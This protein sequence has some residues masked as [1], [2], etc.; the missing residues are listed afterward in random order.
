MPVRR[1]LRIPGVRFGLIPAA[2]FDARHA[3]AA[4][5]PQIKQ[6][7]ADDEQGLAQVTRTGWFRE[8]AIKSVDAHASARI[9]IRL[10]YVMVAHRAVAYCL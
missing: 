5:R 9:A 6:T 4:L 1:K 7:D 3:K 2:C 10:R 8:V